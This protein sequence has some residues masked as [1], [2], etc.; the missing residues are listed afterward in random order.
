MQA[1]ITF[2]VDCCPTEETRSFKSLRAAKA[3]AS[4]QLRFGWSAT[5]EAGGEVWRRGF[6]QQPGLWGHDT[7]KRVA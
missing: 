1:T 2:T 3:Y 6:W 5:I 4:K 7:W